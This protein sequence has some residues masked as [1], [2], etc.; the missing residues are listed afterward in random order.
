MVFLWRRICFLTLLRTLS[1]IRHGWNNVVLFSAHSSSS[2]PFPETTLSSATHRA[3]GQTDSFEHVHPLFFRTLLAARRD[4][5]ASPRASGHQL[6][7][8]YISQRRNHLCSTL[9]SGFDGRPRAALPAF[10][11]VLPLIKLTSA[12]QL[13]TPKNGHCFHPCRYQCTF[14]GYWRDNHADHLRKGNECNMSVSQNIP[15]NE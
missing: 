8:W 5:D 9:P 12:S 10:N 3:T 6:T 11:A 2:P 14:A 13:Q 15:Y 1:E 7:W 4:G